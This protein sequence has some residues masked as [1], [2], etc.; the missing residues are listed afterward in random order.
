MKVVA[1]HYGEHDLS[2]IT[3]LTD[4]YIVYD[5]G[6]CGLPNRIERENKGD[7][8]YDKLTYLVDNYYELPDTFL[9]TKSNIFQFITPEEFDEVKNNTNYTPILTKNHKTYSDRMGRVCYYAEEIYWERNDDWVLNVIP[10]KYFFSFKDWA[11]HF[12][13]PNPEYIPFAPGGSY[14]LTR[15]K[16]HKYS[17]DLY[18]EMRSF[19]PYCQRPAEAHLVERSYHLLWK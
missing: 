12:G 3:D 18:D 16:V 4:D 13:L 15:E 2:W 17:R 14:I 6:D 11:K 7:A 1:T 9:L 19:L 5:R 8:D 10:P